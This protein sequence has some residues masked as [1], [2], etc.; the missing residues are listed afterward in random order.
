[1]RSDRMLPSRQTHTRVP[2]RASPRHST[3]KKRAPFVWVLF[4]FVCLFCFVGEIIRCMYL[5]TCFNGGTED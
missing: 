4:L 1:M 5:L 3:L 2:P